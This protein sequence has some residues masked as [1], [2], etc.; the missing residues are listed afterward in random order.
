MFGRKL[1]FLVYTIQSRKTNNNI[2]LALCETLGKT[3]ML[4]GSIVNFFLFVAFRRC[5]MSILADF[6][7]P[8]IIQDPKYK[9]SQSGTYYAPPKSEYDQYVEFIKVSYCNPPSWVW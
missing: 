9:F 5:L 4:M 7:T 6:Y 1:V 8:D 3:L 2:S